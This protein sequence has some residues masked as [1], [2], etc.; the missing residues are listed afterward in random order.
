M[1]Q[2]ETPTQ[3]FFTAIDAAGGRK[4]GLRAARDEAALA[5]AL[6]EDGLLLLKS[7]PLPAWTAR[8]ADMPL[9]DQVEFNRQVGEMVDRGVPLIEALEVGATVVTPET[10]KKVQRIRSLVAGGSSFADACEQV[11]GFDPIA[12]T[13]YRA[14]ERSGD[15]GDAAK[16][17][18]IAAGRRRAIATK[19]ITLMIYP[20]IVTVVSL[21]VATIVL[22][23]VVPQIG[24][25]LL[26]QDIELKWYTVAVMGVGNF[27]RANGLY[28]L[29][30]VAII[31][32]AMVIGRRFVLAAG[33]VVLRQLPG[34]AGLNNAMESARFFAVMAAM[35]RSGVTLADSLAVATAALSPGPLRSQL[36][37]MRRRLV[38]GGVLRNLLEEIEAFPLATRRL[39]VA[40]ERS[41]DIDSV[42]ESLSTDMAAEVDKRS[43]RLLSLLEPM[44]IV[45]MFLVIG[46][47]LMSI[48][49]PLITL[50]GEIQ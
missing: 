46:S 23:V 21:I 39:L 44:F 11:G 17:I 40:A 22:T 29:L 43:E 47:L 27:L 30:L 3:Y 19:A 14:A 41:G 4:R 15:L 45:G 12:V 42:F 18:A 16:R 35:T 24:E 34:V 1:S 49:I 28:V 6:T 36:E 48:M 20:A 26:A 10:S 5:E 9:K 25:S 38:E 7:R 2:I 50:S 31:V 32:G 33:G 8:T 13:V 37:E